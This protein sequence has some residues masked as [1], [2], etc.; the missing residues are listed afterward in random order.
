MGADDGR[1]G[2]FGSNLTF[3]GSG[4][5]IRLLI[6]SLSVVLGDLSGDGSRL[7]EGEPEKGM[8]VVDKFRKIHESF[9]EFTKNSQ[10]ES[11]KQKCT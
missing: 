7:L 5:S 9:V 8:V 11:K 1:S 2:V 4:N 6:S 3:T 10:K